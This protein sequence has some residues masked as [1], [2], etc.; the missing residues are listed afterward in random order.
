MRGRTHA[1]KKKDLERRDRWPDKAK[2]SLPY[3]LQIE[4]ITSEIFGQSY[5]VLFLS[6]VVVVCM[7]C[8]DVCMRS[9]GTEPNEE[10][11]YSKIRCS[12]EIFLRRDNTPRTHLG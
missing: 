7:S 6:Y 12:N 3:V 1:W 10:N 9:G 2:I 5:F 8:I 4:N 11:G